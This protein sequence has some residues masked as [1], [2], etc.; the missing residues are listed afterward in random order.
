MCLHQLEERRM[1]RWSCERGPVVIWRTIR[2]RIE[3]R[4]NSCTPLNCQRMTACKCYLRCFE[5]FVQA[6]SVG[7]RF[8]LLPVPSEKYFTPAQV[9]GI[10]LTLTVCGLQSHSAQ[11]VLYTN[12]GGTWRDVISRSCTAS[13]SSSDPDLSWLHDL[14]DTKRLPLALIG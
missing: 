12:N 13:R 7:S 3:S 5:P 6:Q 14:Y 9:R 2:K 4:S 1:C 8:P 11:Q 10:V